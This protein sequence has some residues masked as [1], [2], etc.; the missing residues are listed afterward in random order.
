MIAPWSRCARAGIALLLVLMSARAAAEVRVRI[1]G[2]DGAE[3]ANVEARLSIRARGKQK[4]LDEPQVK[5]LH[6]QAAQE[7]REALQPF[8][9]YSPEIESE[10]EGGAPEWTARYRVR[11]GPPTRVDSVDARFDGEGADFAPLMERIERAPLKPGERLKHEDYEATKK[12]MSDAAFA[13]GFLDARWIRSELRV[14]PQQQTAQAVLHLDT[15]PR[16]YFGPVTIEQSGIKPE[17][18]DR[19]V[20]I[21]EGTVFDPQEILDLQFRLGDLGYFQSVEIEPQRELAD[22]ERR[23][24][25]LVRTTPRARTKYDFGVGYGTDTGARLSVGSSWRRLNRYGHT[26]NTDFRLSEIKN[27]LGGEYRIPL[28]SEPDEH[29]AFTAATETERLDAGDTFKYVLGTSLNRSPGRWQ[30]RLYLDY[31]H[32]ESEFGDEFTTADLL[33][34]GLSFTRSEP[35]DPI[36]T[37][38]GW[39]LFADVHGAVNKVLASTSFL[40]TRTVL[41][42]IWSPFKRL[43]LIGRTEIGYS[44]VEQFGELPASQRFFAGGDQSVRGYK[45]Q[46]IGPRDSDGNVVGGRFL[47]VF[48]GEAEVRVLQ[49]WGLALFADSGG[50]DDQPGPKLF[51]GVGAGL[52]YR[53]PIGSLQLDF[54]HPL[55]GD[56]SGIRVHIGVRVGV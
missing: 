9:W 1:E 5:R 48:S 26:L 30:R 41:R 25:I 37:R 4:D 2:I 28:G 51:T 23:I 33:T 12:R 56:E 31:T 17:V 54:A 43:R 42:G 35:D 34:P 16:Y 55:D 45:Y 20:E 27:T 6:A 38:R 10:L 50:V 22:A 18:I 49:N 24:P 36:Y 19:Y 39:Y 3:R 8:G 21:R 29:L 52:R 11:L 14:E 53:V 32:E 7:I 44:L 46:T 40:Q 13:N 47:N 15:G